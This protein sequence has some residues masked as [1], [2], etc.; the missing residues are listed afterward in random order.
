[1]ITRV[2]HQVTIII[3]LFCSFLLI[4]DVQGECMDQ[5]TKEAMADF[6]TKQNKY[7][8][9]EGT[10]EKISFHSAVNSESH[11]TILRNGYLLKRKNARGVVFI[12]NGFMC[13]KYDSSF[14]RTML[15]PDFHVV[16]FDFRAH[17]D[18]VDCNQCCTF[19]RDE[20]YDVLGAVNAIKARPDLKDLPRIAY[21]FS[22]GGVAAIEAQ[23]AHPDLFNLMIIDC[24][25]D[26]SKN[27]IKKGLEN[28]RFS[29][30]GYKFSLPGRSF[31]EKYAFHPYIQT[32]LKTLLKTVANMDATTT[33][34]YIFPLNPVNSVKK[35]TVPCFFIHCKHDEK[36]PVEAAKNL[37]NNA[38]GFKRL[39]QTAGRHHFDSLF[40]NFDKYLYKIKHFI[41]IVLDGIYVTKQ[42]QKICVDNYIAAPAA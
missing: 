16:T 18:D 25:Y 21:G 36:V 28:M 12:L 17:G 8:K 24:A 32:L 5:S 38:A 9:P 39:W 1:M 10:L 37:Y 27:V 7:I 15:F 20:A 6:L 19:G 41:N 33:N 22:M 4:N 11:E 13:T 30:F 42:Q 29:L 26:R 34:T 2:K 3:I 23:A 40:F 35:I 31:L 14:L